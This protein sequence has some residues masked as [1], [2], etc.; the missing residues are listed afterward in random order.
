MTT[1]ICHV[2]EDDVRKAL[3]MA[4]AIAVVEEAM[5][6]RAQA[7]AQDK[8]RTSTQYAAGSLRMLSASSPEIGLAGYKMTYSSAGNA[9]QGYFYLIDRESGALRAVIESI[10]LST[11]RTGAA[12][13]V[14]T[15]CLSR[16]DARIVAMIGA[17]TQAMAQLQAVCMVR[18]I[19]S[20]RVFS[21]NYERL[22][23]FCAN[24]QEL[25]KIDV[26]PMGTVEETVRGADIVNVITNSATPVLLG[27]WLEEGQHI[28]AAGANA[29]NRRELDGTA[30][31][32]CNVVVVD[33][34]DVARTEC[35]DI[36]P[37]VAAGDLTWEGLP[38]LGE[39]LL[40]Q[41]TGRVADNQITLYESHGIGVQDLYTARFVLDGVTALA[42]GTSL[43]SGR[44]AFPVSA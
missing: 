19:E 37:L 28:N 34:R 39:L 32:R 25:L 13:G 17:G 38:E 11:M 40:G 24:A 6:A 41:A 10:H 5:R 12:S 23:T 15:R 3:T 21:R 29:L 14:A 31:H 18:T 2:R 44:A 22:R 42:A 16:S 26:T 35:G 36:F 43:S 1:T 9:T 8:P 33:A 7:H 4:D 30:I 27:E 20:A